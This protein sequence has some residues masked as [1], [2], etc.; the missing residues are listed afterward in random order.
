[1]L[2]RAGPLK[3]AFATDGE[4]LKKAQIY[5]APPGRYLLVDGDR[6]SLGHGPHENNAKPAVDPMLRSAAICCGGA[7]LVLS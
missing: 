3:A 2:T 4:V 6:V 5:L 7:V 1:M